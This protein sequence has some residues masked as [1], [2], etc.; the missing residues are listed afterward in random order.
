MFVA[1]VIVQECSDL[2]SAKRLCLE[3]RPEVPL[4]T[5]SA[6]QM[7]TRNNNALYSLGQK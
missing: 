6:Y 5:L 4:K 3:M 2:P 1:V 7:Q